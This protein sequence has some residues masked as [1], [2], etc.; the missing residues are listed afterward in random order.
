MGI[1]EKSSWLK[2]EDLRM[3]NRD[4]D[5]QEIDEKKVAKPK[6]LT[7]KQKIAAERARRKQ[8]ASF[9]VSIP[10]LAETQSRLYEISQ[11][12]NTDV[13]CYETWTELNKE[14]LA[15]AKLSDAQ[16]LK[17]LIDDKTRLHNN[18]VCGIL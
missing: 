6:R 14:R 18:P 16:R 2:V 11:L 12:P 10:S 17:A 9:A 13:S 7:R 3:F 1:S 5:K 15:K 4:G 8:W